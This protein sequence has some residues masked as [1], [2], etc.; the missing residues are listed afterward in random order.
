MAKTPYQLN[1][2]WRKRNPKIRAAT[3][4]RYYQKTQGARNEYKIYSVADEELIFNHDIPDSKLSALIGRSVGAI[5]GKRF[6][7]LRKMREGR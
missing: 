4:K 7:I 2:E 6:I 3:S 1:K 5:Q